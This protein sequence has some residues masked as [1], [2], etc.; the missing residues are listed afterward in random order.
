MPFSCGATGVEVAL[1]CQEWG[2]YEEAED[3]NEKFPSCKLN[4]ISLNY[5]NVPRIRRTFLTDFRAQKP[6]RALY[7][8]P[9]HQISQK[10][11]LTV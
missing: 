9:N 5:R 7:V 3:I 2:V 1:R 4:A 10:P 6:G 11:F 8:G